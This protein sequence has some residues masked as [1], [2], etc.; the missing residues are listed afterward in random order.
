MAC[1]WSLG[2]LAHASAT[3]QRSRERWLA[4]GLAESLGVVRANSSANLWAPRATDADEYVSV[5]LREE[6]PLVGPDWDD[7]ATIGELQAWVS[8]ALFEAAPLLSRSRTQVELRLLVP[9]QVSLAR[10]GHEHA[11]CSTESAVAAKLPL[12][13]AQPTGASLLDS[14]EQSGDDQGSLLDAATQAPEMAPGDA[15]N[16]LARRARETGY[17]PTL[18]ARVLD[19]AR[20]AACGE[21]PTIEDIRD[22]IRGTLP[23]AGCEM[24]DGMHMPAFIVERMRWQADRPSVS[25]AQRESEQCEPLRF[26]VSFQPD[27]SLRADHEALIFNSAG[28][29][30]AGAS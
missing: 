21:H 10:Q 24:E 3:P 18:A 16:H 25:D 4:P 20:D 22:E 7:G 6:L 5:Q 1:V 11:S 13:F 17:T 23:R 15:W 8:S 30:L 2:G 9:F 29:V 12:P 26:S 27:A 19:V 14:V 28:P